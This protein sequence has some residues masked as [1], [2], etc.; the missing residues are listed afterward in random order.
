M[1]NLNKNALELPKEEQKQ[2]ED[3]YAPLLEHDRKENEKRFKCLE[4]V[5]SK[6]EKPLYDE[7]LE[8]I[9]ECEFT[10]QFEISKNTPDI[11]TKQSEDFEYLKE[12]FVDQYCNGGYVGDDFA[13]WVN[14]KID[15][16]E[17]LKF[18]YSM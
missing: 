17:Y 18:H 11:K 4:Y 12:V 16:D 6:V 10:D 14:I 15:K 5:K 7:I 2:W 8:Y 3:A 13:G 1:N 9:K